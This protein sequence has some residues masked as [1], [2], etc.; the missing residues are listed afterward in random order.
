MRRL[1]GRR[2]P[3]TSPEPETPPAPPPTGEE[4]ILAVL[5]QGC[6]AFVFPMLD[7]GYVYL[8]AARLSLYRSADDWAMAFEIFGYAPR[9]A[10]PDVSVWTFGSRLARGRTRAEYATQAAYDAYLEVHPHDDSVF[11]SP[12]GGD[13]QKAEWGELVSPAATSVTVRGRPIEIPDRATFARHGIELAE[14]DHVRTYELCRYLADVAREGVLATAD[15]RRTACRPSSTNSWSSTTG[16]IRT[17]STGE[18]ASDT[19]AFR[20]LATALAS[21]DVGDVRRVGGTEH[22]LVELALRRVP[23]SP[24]ALARPRASTLYVRRRNAEPT[25]PITIT[26][27]TIARMMTAGER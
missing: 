5:D 11:F 7:N 14:P 4:A 18:R 12:I 16:T 23:V 21:G 27:P 3:E 13:W 25:A 9:A 19:V 6:D 1:F 17:R 24:I 10:G 22:A 20:S 8:A 26:R 2:R 15:E